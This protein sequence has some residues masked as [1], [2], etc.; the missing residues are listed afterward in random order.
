MI[1]HGARLRENDYLPFRQALPQRKSRHA[2]LK[3]ARANY[4]RH[5]V[6]KGY[7]VQYYAIQCNTKQY[8]YKGGS[9]I[10]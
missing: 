9:R 10:F 5:Y 8:L 1:G 6:Q 4:V 2:F 3:C 7:T